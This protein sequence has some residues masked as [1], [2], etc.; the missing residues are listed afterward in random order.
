M[1]WSRTSFSRSWP[2][3]TRYPPVRLS[4]VHKSE[5][6]VPAALGVVVASLAGC[7]SGP[8]EPIV[9]DRIFGVWEWVRAEGGIAGDTAY[10]APGIDFDTTNHCWVGTSNSSLFPTTSWSFKTTVVTAL[11]TTGWHAWIQLLISF[12]D[13]VT[14]LMVSERTSRR[15]G[16]RSHPRD[17]VV[18]RLGR[19]SRVRHPPGVEIH[20]RVR[21]DR[22]P[23]ST[24]S[25]AIR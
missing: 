7:S 16:S 21:H 11:S 22:R 8:T 9:N 15:S 10:F 20:Q 6:L 2:S 25:C 4:R 17:R 13:R 24:P 5:N 18:R 14:P 19:E 23:K 3:H 12:S 1:V